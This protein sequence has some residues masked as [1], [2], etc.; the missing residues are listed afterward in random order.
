MRIYP[1]IPDIIQ[2]IDP[3]WMEDLGMPRRRDPDALPPHNMLEWVMS[4]LYDAV[5]ALGGG[6]SLFAMKAGVLTGHLISHRHP[7]VLSHPF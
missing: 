1:T 3:S 5:A 2:G 7:K 6:N 4:H